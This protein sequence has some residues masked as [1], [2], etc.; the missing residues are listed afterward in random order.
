M[1]FLQNIPFVHILNKISMQTVK[2]AYTKILYIIKANSNLLRI[3]FKFSYKG[4]FALFKSLIVS[5]L[6]K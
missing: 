1:F 4:I 5:E 2:K 3:L 6:R